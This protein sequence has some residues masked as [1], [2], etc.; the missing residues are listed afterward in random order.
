MKASSFVALSTD[1]LDDIIERA[2]T[3]C[4]EQFLTQKSLL[5]QPEEHPV[6]KSWLTLK[7][8]AKYLGVRPETVRTSYITQGLPYSKRGKLLYFRLEDID[9]WLEEGRIR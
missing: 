5:A 1:D 7:E 3:R 9:R 8:A 4:V 2:T 6:Q